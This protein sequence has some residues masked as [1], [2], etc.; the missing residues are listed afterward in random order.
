MVEYKYYYLDVR[1]LGEAVRR[2]FI[3][4]DQPFEDIRINKEQ[5]PREKPSKKIK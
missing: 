4:A 2:L 5:W 1:G 3:Y